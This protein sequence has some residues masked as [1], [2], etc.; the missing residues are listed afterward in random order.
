MTI[1]SHALTRWIGGVVLALGVWFTAL[2]ALTIAAEP[3]RMVVVFAPSRGAMMAAVASADVTLL[4]GSIRMLNVAGSSPGFVARLYAS[5]AWLVLPTR[6]S[7]C[8]TPPSRAA[9]Q[10]PVR[11]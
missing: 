11:G 4:N 5:G 8:F 9:A 10:S 2:I 6:T 3:T 1:R 7:G